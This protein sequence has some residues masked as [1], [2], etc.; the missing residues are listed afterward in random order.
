[1]GLFI[2]GRVLPAFNRFYILFG[3]SRSATMNEL[4]LLDTRPLARR[5]PLPISVCLHVLLI[6]VLT[7]SNAGAEKE[8]PSLVSNRRSVILLHLRD[9]SYPARRHQSS[10]SQ[11]QQG[12]AGAGQRGGSAASRLAP[13]PVASQQ[14]SAETQTAQ[15]APPHRKFE[16]SVA[17]PVVPEKQTIVQL[18]VPPEIALK[19]DM[20]LPNIIVWTARQPPPFRR[21]FVAPPLKQARQKVIAQN[22]T[23]APELQLPNNEPNVADLKLAALLAAQTRHFVVPPATTAPIRVPNPELSSQVPQIVVPDT[24]SAES[25]ALMALVTSP[26]KPDGM[27]IVPPANQSSEASGSSSGGQRPATDKGEGSGGGS[28]PQGAGSGNTSDSKPGGGKSGDGNTGG[29]G[30][31]GGR[32]SGSGVGDLAS[33]GHGGGIG[34]GNSGTGNGSSGTGTGSSSGSSSG[35]GSG[36]T[37]GPGHGNGAAGSGDGLDVNIVGVTRITLPKEGKY[38]VVVTGS[39]QAVPYPETVGALTGKMVYT[40]YLNVGLHKKWILQ[41]CLAKEALRSIPRGGSTS[42]DAPWP[43]LIFRP[44]HLVEPNDYVIVHG[45]IDKDGRF[46]QLAMVFPNQFDQKDLLINSLK[47]WAFRAASRDH[48]PTA[49]EV[50]LIIPGES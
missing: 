2:A 20:P 9:F 29:A 50:L 17:V 3:S 27:I 40:V 4:S 22:I 31:A 48:V 6:V 23:P 41:Y 5:S 42:V 36:G 11:G 8:S 43:F 49:V 1:M 45:L 21:Q 33:N 19:Q 47:I 38:T 16:L 28:Q 13:A 14:S 32:G 26:V 39:S 24:N 25:A 34:N 15:V 44:D 18:Q 46:D 12:L 10:G 30:S 37:G 35:S 7:L